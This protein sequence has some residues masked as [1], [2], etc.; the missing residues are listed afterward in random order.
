MLL[1][2]LQSNEKL[3]QIDDFLSD[4][5][6]NLILKNKISFSLRYRRPVEELIDRKYRRIIE[7]EEDESN[8]S[9]IRT[10]DVESDLLNLEELEY[11]QRSLHG[12]PVK[13]VSKKIKNNPL[14]TSFSLKNAIGKAT[15]SLAQVAYNPNYILN[16][17]TLVDAE[18]N[19]VNEHLQ[20][21]SNTNNL[22]NIK[23]SNLLTGKRSF[24]KLTSWQ[25]RVNLIEIRHL[26][27][28][29][30]EVY[31]TVKIGDNQIFKSTIKQIDKL[32]F[33]EVFTARFENMRS[34]R[35]LN[36]V[37]C[38]CVYFKNFLKSDDLIG[39]FEVDLGTVYN[40]PNHECYHKWGSIMPAEENNIS[41]GSS[42]GNYSTV[43]N[44]KAYVKLDIM[45]HAKG[46]KTISHPKED[47]EKEEEIDNNM[48]LPRGLENPRVLI[49]LNVNIYSADV[50][51]KY[52]INR[53]DKIKNQIINWKSLIWS[54]DDEDVFTADTKSDSKDYTLIKMEDDDKIMD[55]DDLNLFVRIK[56]CGITRRTSAKK[57][58]NKPI[59]N[60]SFKFIYQ[61]PSLLRLF[62]IEL[63]SEESFGDRVLATEYLDI[64]AISDYTSKEF[65]PSFGPANIDM[66][67][68]PGN[69]RIRSH[70]LNCS[71]PDLTDLAELL[72]VKEETV[73]PQVLNRSYVPINGVSP[74]GGDYVARLLFQIESFKF[75]NSKQKINLKNCDNLKKNE[76]NMTLFAMIGDVNM[77]DFRYQNDLSF[78][79]CIGTNGYDLMHKID[80]TNDHNIPSNFTKKQKS[81]RLGPKL[82]FYLPFDKSKPCMS[83]NFRIEDIRYHMYAKNF[84]RNSIKVLVFAA[85]G[86]FDPEQD[87]E[88]IVKE[89]LIEILKIRKYFSQ[90]FM[91]SQLLTDL[92]RKRSEQLIHE[93]NEIIKLVQSLQSENKADS[94]F[95][96]FNYNRIMQSIRKIDNY[97]AEPLSLFPDVNLWLLSCNEPIGIC[98]IKSNDIIWSKQ[99]YHK[100][101]ICNRMIYTDIKSLN[102]KDFEKPITE[103]I[104]RIRVYLWLGLEEET[105]FIFENLPLGYG[106][107]EKFFNNINLPTQV[108]YNEK[109]SFELVAHIYQGRDL[110]GL[111]STGLSD[112]YVKLTLG[113]QSVYSHV[114]TQTNNPKWNT[115]LLIPEIN[116]YSP[117]ESIAQNPPE[118]ILEIYDKDLVGEHELMG[119]CPIKPVVQTKRNNP[120]MLKWYKVFHGSEHAGDILASF[121]LILLSSENAKRK[122]N[123]KII[124]IPEYIVPIMSTYTL[125]II[126]WGLRNTKL[127]NSVLFGREKI[128]ICVQIGDQTFYSNTIEKFF[129][130]DNFLNIYQKHSIELPQQDEYK[131]HLNIKCLCENSIGKEQLI[132]SFTVKTINDY[133]RDLKDL[134]IKY[135]NYSQKE[136][137]KNILRLNSN[138]YDRNMEKYDFDT[139]QVTTTSNNTNI[140]KQ[141][142]S[143]SDPDL[144]IEYLDWW[145]KYYASINPDEVEK[146]DK[147]ADIE[148]KNDSNDDLPI[149]ILDEPKKIR[150]IKR[151]P[152]KKL[153]KKASKS[154]K[155]KNGIKKPDHKIIKHELKNNKEI[156]VTDSKNKNVEKIEIFD[157]ELEKVD[158]FSERFDMLH[159]FALYKG[160]NQQN[161]IEAIQCHFKG[162]FLIY[163]ESP[164]L[165]QSFENTILKR[166]GGFFGL[167]PPNTPITVKIRVY[168]VNAVL[169]PVTDQRLCDPYISIQIA[170]KVYDYSENSQHETLEPNFGCMYEYDVKFPYESQITIAIKDWS[171]LGN[172]GLIGKTV[173][174]LEDRFYSSCY[175]MCGLPKKYE[176]SGYNAWR[177]KLFPT[178]ILAQLCRKWRLNLPEYG[179]DWLKIYKSD[180][181]V[182]EYKYELDNERNIVN[183]NNQF[184]TSYK[185]PGIDYRTIREELALTALNDWHN[186]TGTYLVPEH[187]ETRYLYNP[188][189]PEFEQ[190]KLRM[191]IDMFSLD[192]SHNTSPNINHI[193]K[194]IDISPR[195]PKKFQLRVNVY[196]TEDVTLDDENPLTGERSSDIYVRAYLADKI[197]E[198]QRTDTH[199]RSLNGE[200][201]F[202]WRFIFDFEYLPA[203][204]MIIYKQKPS[205]FSLFT[206]EKKVDPIITFE[207]WDADLIS[208][209]DILG[210]LQLDLSKMIKG[211]KSSSFCK[212]SML[213]KK[214]NQDINL[215]KVK[216]HRGW[217]PFSIYDSGK[218][219]KLAGK[220]EAEFQLLTE[221]QA[222][223]KPAGLGR[224]EPDPLP[225][226]QRE[227]ESFAWFLSPL[228][229]FRYRLIADRTYCYCQKISNNMVQRKLYSGY[230]KRPVDFY[231]SYCATDK[232]AL[233]MEYVLKYDKNLRDLILEDDLA[234]LDR[235]FNG[236][237][238][239]LHI[240]SP[241]S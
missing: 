178:Q 55:T 28:T 30:K 73:K 92:E 224:K 31:C 228:K 199:F 171:L 206:V 137:S 8:K 193:P 69:Q 210:S 134:R 174:D 56:F 159:T 172:K 188:D 4:P 138:Y 143:K 7:L 33:N 104:A 194:P 64:E 10:L 40:Q 120:P 39:K 175:A 93:L 9:F 216:N 163:K 131:P 78:Q 103:N 230:K 118:I 214:N 149:K 231:R 48:I 81:M 121:E 3:V 198:A 37:I 6:T 24:N 5:K 112:P 41:V 113:N 135:K 27:G 164:D 109:L 189:M 183:K 152:L 20:N 102:P 94:T 142:D 84:L 127:N 83:L 107:H 124:P 221:Q 237:I 38:V 97:F 108:F 46:D 233:I 148:T 239:R 204:E 126:F 95:R 170:D 122:E 65:Y 123:D 219:L 88:E 187:L 196:N 184:I 14:S 185:L 66:Y 146:I 211:A 225:E 111:D 186:I 72:P 213:K 42:G 68:E 201:K 57:A 179:A 161:N 60:E 133:Y 106:L 1:E 150:K 82:P 18:D 234:I 129:S 45:V 105:D 182:K 119:K 139:I 70:T 99:K 232:D 145:S 47:L 79:L 226:P 34:Q 158:R 50:L 208:S 98:T 212:L 215:F 166:Y 91:K 87:T 62:Q 43:S 96:K 168:I 101:V 238:L 59:W 125:E 86:L 15:L 71:S 165:H 132:G 74:G 21:L 115:S 197:D 155:L 35:V 36:Q 203:E 220:L 110:L 222:L 169:N 202:N 12:E 11:M 177:D 173:I 167:T 23:P 207:C 240:T 61:F 229:T 156:V 154:K 117:Y 19:I 195:K 140:V 227:D 223:E 44:P 52:R 77:I 29:N 236:Y 116:L 67:S 32:R 217:W 22:E 162:N 176:T 128:K 17:E 235:D 89:Y 54:A 13:Q 76:K 58:T 63:C 49:E 192:D 2:S 144:D 218:S 141:K 181:S 26:L 90:V 25:V 153:R 136:G 200:G 75:E 191:W 241:S 209:D 53:F 51:M 16:D 100:G 205:K 130:N 85:N 114:I 160:K 190:G 180:E 80:L 151:I 147:E 157:C